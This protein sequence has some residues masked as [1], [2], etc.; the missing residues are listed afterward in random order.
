MSFLQP[1]MLMALPVIALPIIIHLINQRR[2]Q[3]V[4]WAAMQ[5]LLTASRMSRGY[6]RLRQWLILAA[7]TL[8]IAGLIFAISRPLS[9]GWLGLT[10][11]GRVDTTIILLDRSPSML[12]AGPGS[13]TKL[14][15]GIDQLVQSLSMLRSNRYVLIDS[16]T[17]K[18]IEIESPAMLADLPETAP[19]SESAD[20]PAMLEIAEDYIRANRPSRCE[21]WICSDVR[22]NDWKDESGRWNA[23][24][25]SL[26]EL[27]QM[28]RFHLLAY[29]EADNTNR[30]L[31]V[32]R[33]R[34]VD[35]DD[36]PQLLLSLR[37]DQIEPVEGRETIPIQLELDGARSEFTAE[38][39]GTELDLRNHVVPLDGG[40]TRGWGRISIPSDASPS[41]NEFYFVYDKSIDR[42]TLIVTDDPES[43]RPLEFAAS[44]SADP[45]VNC[46]T[47][48]ITP[49]QVVGTPI[50]EVSLLLW[51]SALPSRDDP[52]LPMVQS[53]L[54]RGGQA[55]FFPPESP[56]ETEFAGLRWT[57][58]HEQTNVPVTTWVGDQDLLA[59][60][61]SG[62]SLPVGELKV[63]RYC[64]LEGVC[65]SLAT[66]DGGAPL[67]ARAMTD[68][69][70]VYFCCTTTSTA[71]SSFARDGVVLYAMIHRA[72]AAGA[73]SLGNTRQFIAGDVPFDDSSGWQRLAGNPDAL[74]NTYA[75]HAG[76]YR[77]DDQ[78]LAINRGEAEDAVTI[79]P[80]ERVAA[81]FDRLD[82]DRV[83]DQAGSGT[84]LIQE[85]W[86][87]FLVMM[88]VA[89]L[90][91][92]ALCIP[93]RVAALSGPRGQEVAG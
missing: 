9:S 43:V 34:S 38:M 93:R 77:F 92:A 28:V 46:T 73:Q 5:F 12:Q 40:Q 23:I 15:A 61:R 78:L 57:L 63:S 76:T 33:V 69:R 36:G 10:G 32:T 14:Q 90:L 31:R 79:V 25:T 37:V 81:L 56:T 74:S 65:T 42:R 75:E 19:V 35:S 71:D 53:L 27:P 1:A 6:A 91:E 85:I 60:A 70:N 87:L 83:D 18:A 88:M 48:I 22:K 26:L 7:R 82:F 2:F 55:I 4:P 30:S 51:Q 52:A 67:L 62:A 17:E 3:T 59:N 86:R 11:G 44:V 72:L 47:T 29:S 16:A 58:W 66:L 50:E 13:V 68:Q 84:S 21:V 54:D 24:R 8:A 80:R 49:E 20:I 89:L 64:E 45:E 39:T 41:D